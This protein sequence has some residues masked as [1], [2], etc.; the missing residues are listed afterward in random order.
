MLV[1]SSL[2]NKVSRRTSDTSAMTS[3]KR[4]A[5]GFVIKFFGRKVAELVKRLV[6]FESLLSLTTGRK[7]SVQLGDARHLPFRDGSVAAVITSPPYP[8][9]YDYIE[10]HRIRLRWLGLPER[11]LDRHEIGAKRQSQGKGKANFR[12][13]F[14]QQLKQCLAEMSRVL[15]PAG[16]LAVVMADSVVDQEPWYADEEISNLASHVGLNLVAHAAQ[17]QRHFHAPTEIAFAHRPRC[18]RLLLLRSA[19]DAT[20]RLKCWTDEQPK[21]VRSR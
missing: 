10:H 1:L 14:N 8:G 19:N 20:R 13:T 11:H 17:R 18:E 4:W 15:A 3:D 6:E 9:V 7:S 2:L 21:Q 5:A 12:N 16:S